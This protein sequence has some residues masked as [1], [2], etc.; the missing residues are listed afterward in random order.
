M[1]T[2]EYAD[3][4]SSIIDAQVYTSLVLS[5]GDQLNG[6]KD[7][8]DKAD[9]IEQTVESASDDKLKWVDGVGRDHIDIKTG[10]D[11]EFKYMADGL[12]TKKGK[13]KATVKVKVKNSL[14]KNKGITIDNPAD[15]Y[16][17]GQQNAIAVIS[18]DELKKFLVSVP[19]GIE[20]IIPFDTLSFIF[21]PNDVN[22][23]LLVNVNYKEVKRRAQKDLI[24]SVKKLVKNV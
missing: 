1:T 14:G 20:A 17:L 6:P 19:D 8:F 2:K 16:L 3:Y 10:V 11:L 13:P 24:E 21:T 9:I 7:R 18:W 23:T 22:Q 4:L 12:F 15:F 5:L